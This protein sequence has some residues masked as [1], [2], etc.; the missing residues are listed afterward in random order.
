M[1]WWLLLGHEQKT[2]GRPCEA[3]P[4]SLGGTGAAHNGVPTTTTAAAAA[5]ASHL[6]DALK[7]KGIVDWIHRASPQHPETVNFVLFFLISMVDLILILTLVDDVGA[8]DRSS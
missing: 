7:K 5:A 1:S 6:W 4:R 2:I 8:L 3:Q